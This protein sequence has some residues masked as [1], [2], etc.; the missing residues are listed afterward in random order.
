MNSIALSPLAHTWLIDVDGPVLVHNGYHKGGDVLLPDVHAFWNQ[1]PS[2]D[3]IILLSARSETE[4]AAT[5]RFFE[6]HCLRYDHAIFGLPMGERVLINDVK[7]SGL[8]TALALNVTRDEGLGD[9]AII[10]DPSR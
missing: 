7:P 2:G 3:T 10:L 4:K 5:L 6:S 1:I 8:H 9:I